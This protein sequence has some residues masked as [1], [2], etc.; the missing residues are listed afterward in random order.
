MNTVPASFGWKSQWDGYDPGLGKDSATELAPGW[1]AQKG[2]DAVGGSTDTLATACWTVTA[3]PGAGLATW[4]EVARAT[5][6]AEPF[7][8][9]VTSPAEL[10]VA[11]AG[12]SLVQ[13]ND[14]PVTGLP[15]ESK[16]VATS[17]TVAPRLAGE[18]GA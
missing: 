14:A 11:I 9:A 3:S 6:W 18:A 2:I 15:P 13:P 16:A 10:T 5:T 12:A 7:A 4:L 17:W 1:G 8:T